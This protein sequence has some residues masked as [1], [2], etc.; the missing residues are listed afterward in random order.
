MSVFENTLNIMQKIWDSLPI[1]VDK[2]S[3]LLLS[4]FTFGDT[5][6]TVLEILFSVGLSAILIAKII[7]FLL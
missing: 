1:F 6:F 2:I 7:K 3:S 5:S 4:S